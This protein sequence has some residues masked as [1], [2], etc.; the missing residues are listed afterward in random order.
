M[1]LFEVIPEVQYDLWPFF[2]L[3]LLPSFFRSVFAS[4]F[5]LASLPLSVRDKYQ[6]LLFAEWENLPIH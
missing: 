1:S 5:P 4:I 6:R 3:Y 2:C